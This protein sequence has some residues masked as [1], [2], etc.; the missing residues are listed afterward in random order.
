MEAFAVRW[1]DISKLIIL[2]VITGVVSIIC[3]RTGF[4]EYLD[5]A[6]FG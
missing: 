6:V 3:I 1:N 4:L 5:K 2:T